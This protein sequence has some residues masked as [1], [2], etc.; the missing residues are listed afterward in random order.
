MSRSRL[1]WTG[2]LLCLA[3]FAWTEPARGQAAQ[4]QNRVTLR[5]LLPAADAKLKI[6]G[7]LTKKT[8]EVRTFQSPPLEPGKKYFYILE[9][10]WEP[11]NYTTRTRT[12]RVSVEPGKEVE[13]DLRKEDDKNPDN[14]VIRFVPTPPEVVQ[15]MVK[16]AGVGKDDVVFDLGCGDGRMVIAAVK[17]GAKKGIG[18]DLDL[19]RLKECKE[20]AKKEG[21]EDRV[22]F[23][24]G[25][26]LKE[27]KD[28]SEATVILLYMSDDLNLAWR[29]ILQ[30]TLKPGTRI[31]S[32]RFIMGDWKPADTQ[33]I[34]LDGEKYLIHLWKIAEK[35]EKK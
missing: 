9:A 14:I 16:L 20:N 4:E 2:T 25:N 27:I 6:D 24:Q 23:R 17:A 21:V 26:V 13:V 28:L 35:D 11:N 12:R 10:I 15:A 29:P 22:E 33:T 7:E 5:V 19:E 18:V 8:G 30:K 34:D 1:V 3:L 31:V 32:H